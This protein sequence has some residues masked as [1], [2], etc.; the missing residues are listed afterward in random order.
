MVPASCAQIPEFMHVCVC[1]LEGLS[2]KR[3]REEKIT[4]NIIGKR[5]FGTT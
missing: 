3:E 1:L 2:L 4:N 5:D